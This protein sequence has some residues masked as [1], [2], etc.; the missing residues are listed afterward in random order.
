MDVTIKRRVFTL[1]THIGYVIVIIDV[2]VSI[3]QAP[4]IIFISN[5]SSFAW[6]RQA[7]TNT[8]GIINSDKSNARI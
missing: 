1:L 8:Q 6:T 2:F 4:N 7:G 3:G 5:I